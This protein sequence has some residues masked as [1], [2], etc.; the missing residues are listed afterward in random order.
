MANRATVYADLNQ[1]A[2]NLAGENLCWHF[3]SQTTLYE[4]RNAAQ[5]TFPHIFSISPELQQYLGPAVLAA[6][7]PYRLQ[8]F[9]DAFV[10]YKIQEKSSEITWDRSFFRA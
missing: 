2:D 3:E 7:P 1:A 4:W 5:A 8:S 9:A 10:V 6:Q